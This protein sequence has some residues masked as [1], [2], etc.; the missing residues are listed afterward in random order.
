MSKL[1]FPASQPASQ[2]AALPARQTSSHDA[3][4]EIIRRGKERGVL[5]GKTH[6]LKDSRPQEG[7]NA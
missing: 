1:H 2:P 6:L 3:E 4:W 7:V 5:L